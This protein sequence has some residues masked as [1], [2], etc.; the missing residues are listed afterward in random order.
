MSDIRLEFKI[1]PLSDKVKGFFRTF[2]VFPFCLISGAFFMDSASPA[3]PSRRIGPRR[4][5]G[6][7]FGNRK[8]CGWDWLCNGAGM[9]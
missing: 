8:K 1:R 9:G 4:E 2:F 7:S 3:L 5:N 6:R